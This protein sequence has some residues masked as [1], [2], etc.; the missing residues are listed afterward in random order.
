MYKYKITFN[1]NN[2]TFCEEFEFV[3]Q[4]RNFDRGIVKKYIIN[5]IYKNLT[6]NIKYINIIKKILF[7][8]IIINNITLID[9][10]NN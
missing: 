4:I 7:D 5:R 3:S 6:V 2:K 9:Y 8:N 1:I 10:N